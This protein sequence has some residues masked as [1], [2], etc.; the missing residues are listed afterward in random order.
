MKRILSPGILIP[1]VLAVAGVALIV[2]GQGIGRAPA[3]T[4]SLP[5]IARTTDAVPSAT[6]LAT[7]PG[8]AT[9]SPIAS[10]AA[11]TLPDDVTAVQLQIEA[12]GINVAVNPSEDD[13]TDD[14]PP[15]TSAFVLQGSAQPGHGSNSYIFAHALEH[16]FKPL[17]NVR[18]GDEVLV[19]MSN[20]QV[21]R[22]RVAEVRPNVPCPDPNADPA[23]D[24]EANG[25]TPPLALQLAG[26][27]CDVS[28]TEPTETERLT[29]QTSQ[30][31]NRNW[32]EFVVVAE[33][34]T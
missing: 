21:L 10:P 17:W 18:I 9:E 26:P 30:G 16:L 15:D 3:P 2:A 14:F 31:Y 19:R 1:L 12:V 34:I 29:L 32:G 33:P 7:A 11:S 25:V 23:L 13:A 27:D 4:S 28:W 5:P 8:T 24:P 20:D 6:P 22:Y